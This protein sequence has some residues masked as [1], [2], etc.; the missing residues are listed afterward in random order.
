[1]NS[2]ADTVNK[3]IKVFSPVTNLTSDI[4]L[5]CSPL[6]VNFK[7]TSISDTTISSWAWDFGDGTQSQL[8]DP[9]KI[10][11]AKKNKNF[12]VKLIVTDVLGCKSSMVKGQYLSVKKPQAFF[13][14]INEEHCSGDTLLIS[15]IP[16]N[17]S[18]YNW[19]FGDGTQMN[20]LNPSK[21]FMIAGN[22]FPELRVMDQFGCLDTFSLINPVIVHE[23]PTSHILVNDPIA[24]CYPAGMFFTNVSPSN[25]TSSWEWRFG[26][27][28]TAFMQNNNAFHSY[29]YPGYYDVCLKTTNQ[30]GC[31]DSTIIPQLISVI[32]PTGEIFTNT[33][34]GCVK[35]AVE[36][37]LTNVNTTAYSFYWD[38]GDGI[39]DTLLKPNLNTIH[40]YNY[41][42]EYNVTLLVSDSA[43]SCVKT[44]Q[45]MVNMIDIT[46][47][48]I[49]SDSIGCHPLNLEFL[50]TSVTQNQKWSIDND[51]Y[52][53]SHLFMHQFDTPGEYN[54]KL[55]IWLDSLSCK[56]TAT[57]KVIVYETPNLESSNDTVIC[58]GDQITLFSTGSDSV[59]W[60]PE[61]GVSDVSGKVTKTQIIETTMFFVEGYSSEGCLDTDSVKVEIVPEPFLIRFPS[62]TAIFEGEELSVMVDATE[63][64]IMQWTSSEFVSCDDCFDPYI[65]PNTDATYYLHYEDE[66]GCHAKDTAF[67]VELLDYSVFIPNSFSPNNDGLND[68]F[69]IEAI[70]IKELMYFYI[71]DRWGALVFETS[72]IDIGWDGYINGQP[73]SNNSIFTYKLRVIAES[74]KTSDFVGTFSAVSW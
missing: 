22:Y 43:G 26:D 41:Q 50:N 29:S 58:L 37:S 12:S 6:S 44:D 55:E 70:G 53:S 21:R 34:I 38:F 8:K 74:S 47:N 24:N 49:A 23:V 32:G 66:Y 28:D 1:M 73:A 27:G 54:V 33:S 11:S 45:V 65:A 36:F 4:T 39:M 18:L 42:M 40:K 30:Y 10:Y 35:K 51:P 31:A 14:I 17:D 72:D 52:R 20:G 61:A 9:K 59:F 60:Y 46:A 57:Q 5:G 25:T 7:D 62:D 2:C 3:L 13:S 64:I 15:D 16:A 67:S 56:D 68:V 48:I 69:K 19:D 63:P 71:Y